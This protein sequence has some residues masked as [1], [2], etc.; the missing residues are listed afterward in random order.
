MKILNQTNELES[1]KEEIKHH[2]FNINKKDE[3]ILFLREEKLKF[4]EFKDK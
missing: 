3:E 1:L 4:I 2:V